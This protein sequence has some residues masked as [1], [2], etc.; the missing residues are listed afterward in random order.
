MKKL[1]MALLIGCFL[2]L[3][4]KWLY[5]LFK[6][7]PNQQLDNII[8]TYLENKFNSSSDESSR[9]FVAFDGYGY[10]RNGSTIKAYGTYESREFILSGNRVKSG[11]ISDVPLVISIEST[12]NGYKVVRCE[13]VRDGS[14]FETDIERMFPW[15]CRSKTYDGTY[16]RQARALCDKRIKAY[17]KKVLTKNSGK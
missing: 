13:E 6:T 2:F 1:I 10:T 15:W 3:G 14:Y 5:V 17:Y 12:K 11:A 16:S 7:Q 8:I 4:A 9:V